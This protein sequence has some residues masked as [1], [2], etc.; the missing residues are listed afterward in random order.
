MRMASKVVVCMIWFCHTVRVWSKNVRLY[1]LAN[2]K[3]IKF[4]EMRNIMPSSERHLEFTVKA[5]VFKLIDVQTDD[6]WRFLTHLWR[7]ELV[8]N[9]VCA[10][11]RH[12][13]HTKPQQYE[14]LNKLIFIRAYVGW[15][16]CYVKPMFT[17]SV[18]TGGHS[19]C[20]NKK[21]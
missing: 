11:R 9:G 18:H 5:Q 7:I 15:I 3:H 12:S 17:F 10:F 8:L 1:V 21:L 20:P 6:R 14:H 16:V 19:S 2:A 4:T 13:Q